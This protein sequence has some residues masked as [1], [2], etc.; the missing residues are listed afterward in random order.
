MIIIQQFLMRS[1]LD[2]EIT[3][4]S[5]YHWNNTSSLLGKITTKIGI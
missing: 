2:I 4:V 3:K 1:E 5:S